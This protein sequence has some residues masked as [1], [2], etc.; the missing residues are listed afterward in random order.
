MPSEPPKA[1]DPLARHSLSA[2]ELKQLLAQERAGEAFLAF[3]DDDGH[4]RFFAA[5]GRGEIS[6]LGRR[7]ETD[8]SIPWD[9][10][11]SGLHAELHHLGGEWAIVDDGLST[12][13]TYVEGQRI[14]GR[15][16][17]RDGDRIRVGR[18]I[19]AFRAAQ[20][21]G[22]GQ[23][24]AASSRPAP[25]LTDMQRR[26]LTALCRPFRDGGFGT[27]AT[28]Q[29]IATEVFLSVD[30]VKMHMRTLFGKFELGD[31]PQN[32]KRAKLAEGALQLGVVSRRDLD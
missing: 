6:T 31:L 24:V 18:T 11:V 30:A 22:V 3:R 4:L 19:L 10:E 17:L 14:G 13:G 26:V 16:R 5:R 8:L 20:A 2:S 25:Q 7:A 21:T 23:T 28:N 1:G 9:G 12:N 27:P 29:E 32:Q 15:Q